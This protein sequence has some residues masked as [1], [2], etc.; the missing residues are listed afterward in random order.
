MFVSWP[1]VCRGGCGL[2][3]HRCQL[4]GWETQPC[5]PCPHSLAEKHCQ[6]AGD[7]IHGQARGHLSCWRSL[8]RRYLQNALFYETYFGL[9]LPDGS[10][11]EQKAQEEEMDR[12]AGNAQAKVNLWGCECAWVCVCVFPVA[13]PRRG[14]GY[15]LQC[16]SRMT[17]LERPPPLQN[18]DI[19]LSAEHCARVS[20][21]SDIKA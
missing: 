1:G 20:F 9:V 4:G 16:P 10:C 18:A 2:D 6:E 13:F 19:C 21:D 3:R 17:Q 11:G 15:L 7:R 14:C 5:Q 8:H 12:A